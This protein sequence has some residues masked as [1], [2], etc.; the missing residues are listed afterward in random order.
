VAEPIDDGTVRYSLLETLRH[1]ALDQLAEHGDVD[2]TRQQHAEHYARVAEALGAMLPGPDENEGRARILAEVDNLRAAVGFGLDARDAARRELALRIIA[3]LAH[4]ITFDRVI[5]VGEWAIRALDVLDEADPRLRSAV[6]AIAGYRAHEQDNGDEAE[7]LGRE[8]IA[9]APPVNDPAFVLTHSFRAS[10]VANTGDIDGAIERLRASRA[11]VGPWENAPYAAAVFHTQI[12]VY[13]GLFGGDTDVAREE[14]DRALRIG[15]ALKSPVAQALALF[16]LSCAL[17]DRDVEASLAAAEESIALAGASASIYNSAL[18][19]VG[20]HRMSLGDTRG[21]IAPLR[22]TLANIGAQ[23]DFPALGGTLALVIVLF[24]RC[25]REE[26]AATT[27][28]VVDDGAISGY[29]MHVHQSFAQEYA[30]ALEQIRRR[31]SPEAF[32]AATA[33]GTAMTYHEAIDYVLAQLDA[34]QASS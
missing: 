32:A 15:R 22:E 13:L 29:P 18:L 9:D 31:L 10:L 28:A 2:E 7:R 1:Y 17:N 16:A 26:S 3:A 30:A 4:E 25:R 11:L 23:G 33:T 6:R 24:E 8:V 27:A 14:A 19:Q 20:V 5:G 21:A 34:A 12:A